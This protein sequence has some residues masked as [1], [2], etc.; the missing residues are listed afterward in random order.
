MDANC[1]LSSLDYP[2]WVGEH[3]ADV[4]TRTS[5]P[6]PPLSPLLSPEQVGAPLHAAPCASSLL[7][8]YVPKRSPY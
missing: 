8:P 2:N 3:G 4:K 6:R 7:H 1:R 5:P